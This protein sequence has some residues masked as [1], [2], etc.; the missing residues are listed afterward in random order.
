M[1]LIVCFSFSLSLLLSFSLSLLLSLSL[2]LF[3]FYETTW[4][5]GLQSRYLRMDASR[6]SNQSFRTA[7]RTPAE[8]PFLCVC[9]CVFYSFFFSYLFHGRPWHACLGR[10]QYVLADSECLNC[11]TK[12]ADGHGWGDNSMRAIITCDGG[13]QNVACCVRMAGSGICQ[14]S[15]MQFWC[16]PARN[17]LHIHN[18]YNPLQQIALAA[19]PAASASCLTSPVRQLVTRDAAVEQRVEWGEKRKREGATCQF[20]T[21]STHARALPTFTVASHQ[22]RSELPIAAGFRISAF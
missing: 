12:K 8:R 18:M 2:S 20:T 10:I 5:L 13:R 4:L 11:F 9:V 1:Q 15:A 22:L 17:Y 14:H 16:K 19:S 21:R 6:L 7:C 3:F